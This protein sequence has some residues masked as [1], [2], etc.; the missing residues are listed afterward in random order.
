MT[1]RSDARIRNAYTDQP[2]VEPLL[3]KVR[4]KLKALDE[5]EDA[6]AAPDAPCPY[7]FGEMEADLRALTD[8]SHA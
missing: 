3:E 6:L 1:M 8:P 7:K 2:Y 5:W 4:R